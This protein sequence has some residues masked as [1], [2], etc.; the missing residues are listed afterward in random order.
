MVVNSQ[1]QDAAEPALLRTEVALSDIKV[2]THGD[3]D[4][5]VKFALR[6]CLPTT[7]VNMCHLSED[8]KCFTS[9]FKTSG[10]SC[11]FKRFME[12]SQ[13]R[14]WVILNDAE[15]KLSQQ[16]H[17]LTLCCRFLESKSQVTASVGSSISA[18]RTQ[19]IT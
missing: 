9:G 2:T 3:E 19:S 5:L 6:S 11:D 17:V 8:V 1:D 10:G 16:H 14:Y 12:T 15:F 4:S 18:W 7:R 13:D